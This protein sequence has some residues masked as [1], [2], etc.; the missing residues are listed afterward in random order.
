MPR[1]PKKLLHLPAWLLPSAG[2]YLAVGLVIE[3]ALLPPA[4][5][6]SLEHA[7]LLQ[8]QNCRADPVPVRRACQESTG[9]RN[10]RESTA[11]QE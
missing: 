1:T 4:G 11:M 9:Q 7:F 3:P 5:D 2:R 6:E 8:E 10:P